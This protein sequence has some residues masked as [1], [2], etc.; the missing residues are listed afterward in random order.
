MGEYANAAITI[1]GKIKRRDLDS[2]VEAIVEDRCG[3]DWGALDE[4]KALAEIEACARE[5]RHLYLCANEASWGQ[6][7]NVQSLCRELGLIHKAEC[8]AGG[9]W[10]PH[11][12][13]FDPA[14]QPKESSQTGNPIS[15]EW[16]I[17]EIGSGPLLDAEE[18]QKH[19]AAGTLA[20]E[21][22]LMIEVTKFPWP[23]EIIEPRRR[24]RKS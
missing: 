19:Y 2:L 11:M 10:H 21:L 16:S 6:F 12:E 24:R 5:K 8:E 23:L 18:V 15:L 13:F 3:P 1:G 22:L 17:T 7:E 4:D 14:R 20:D 9:E